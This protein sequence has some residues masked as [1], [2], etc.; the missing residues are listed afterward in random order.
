M[1]EP[2]H[3]MYGIS[4]CLGKSWSL[5]DSLEIGIQVHGRLILCRQRDMLETGKHESFH[6]VRFPKV[7]SLQ[8]AILFLLIYVAKIPLFHYYF[9]IA[10]NF[11]TE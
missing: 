3:E 10:A 1:K 11:L 8:E 4:L 5:F 2:R 6:G 7:N 9:D